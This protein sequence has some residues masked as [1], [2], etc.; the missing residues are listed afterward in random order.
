MFLCFNYFLAFLEGCLLLSHLFSTQS[1]VVVRFQEAYILLALRAVP[2]RIPAIPNCRVCPAVF[3]SL[4]NPLQL[5]SPGVSFPRPTQPQNIQAVPNH[6]FPVL[7][8]ASSLK[9]VSHFLCLYTCAIASFP[10]YSLL[11]YFLMELATPYLQFSR[12]FF[13]MLFLFFDKH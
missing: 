6:V 13:P 2:N 1:D 3:Q 11:D 10:V 8:Y 12:F 9:G 4:P 7:L 5:P